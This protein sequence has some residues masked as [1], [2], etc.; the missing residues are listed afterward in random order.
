MDT[1]QADAHRLEAGGLN[2]IRRAAIQ[3]SRGHLVQYKPLR[4]LRGSGPS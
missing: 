2:L 3:L 1:G 4:H